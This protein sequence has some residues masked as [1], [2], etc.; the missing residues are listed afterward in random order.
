MMRILSLFI[1]FSGGL[2]GCLG[3]QHPAGDPAVHWGL[4][5]TIP[6]SLPPP[7]PFLEGEASTAAFAAAL[8]E[9]IAQVVK[10]CKAPDSTLSEARG[11][12]ASE[13]FFLAILTTVRG[14]VDTGEQARQMRTESRRDGSAEKVFVQLRA[15][16]VQAVA[17][18]SALMSRLPPPGSLADIHV[19]S[20]LMGYIASLAA[21]IDTGD[22]SMEDY[23]RT[24]EEGS[25]D[26]AYLNLLESINA[27]DGY[28][29]FVARYPWSDGI[30]TPPDI[31]DLQ[32]RATTEIAWVLNASRVLEPPRNG[33]PFSQIY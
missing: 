19:Q 17:D 2:A 14:C 6:A 13:L 30:C 20:T 10:D 1:L 16:A 15:R 9:T 5:L 23:N 18:E 25:L 27:S 28:T 4:G 31:H 29:H 21:F 24:Q 33:E 7:G 26:T 22:K 8:N 32:V 11:Q 3:Q 12:L